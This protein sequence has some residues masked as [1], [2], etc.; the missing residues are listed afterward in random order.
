MFTVQVMSSSAKNAADAAA[1]RVR[2]LTS[3]PVDV[4][5]ESDGLWRVYAGRTTTRARADQ[6]RDRIVAAGYTGAWTKQRV[7]ETAVLDR[8]IPVGES[9]YSAQV[10]VSSSRQNAERVAGEVR[11]KTRMNVEIVE[12][13]GY[14]KIF[15]GRNATR[16]SI[17]LERNRLRDEG[18]PD[19][20]TYRRQG[21]R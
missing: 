9:V 12:M 5:Q 4:V 15:V 1:Q 6:L 3:E 7:V 14:F 20:W 17:D 16:G 13:D 18:Y 11:A 2:S 10:F 21:T 19:A 8:T